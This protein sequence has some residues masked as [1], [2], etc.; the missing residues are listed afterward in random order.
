MY[1]NNLNNTLHEDA[2]VLI[3]EFLADVNNSS[4]RDEV[5]TLTCLFPSCGICFSLLQ[6][7]LAHQNFSCVRN[8]HCGR[9]CI[10]AAARLY[11]CRRSEQGRMRL[12]TF[13]LSLL[14][15]R[16]RLQETRNSPFSQSLTHDSHSQN[17]LS[18]TT[19]VSSSCSSATPSTPVPTSQ[20]GK[21]PVPTDSH[22]GNNTKTQNPLPPSPPV[23]ALQGLTLH[24]RGMTPAKWFCIQGLSIFSSLEYIILTEHQ[25]STEFQPDE[26]VKKDATSMS[27][28][29]LS[30]PFPNEDRGQR[31][32]GGLALL[33]RNSM[34]FSI[35]MHSLSGAVKTILGDNCTSLNSRGNVHGRGTSSSLLQAVTWS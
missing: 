11:L 19:P 30:Q 29:V 2:N 1:N 32:R 13:S 25:Q 10:T 24:I 18:H 15:P 27:Y 20:L 21:R 3:K 5:D 28:P 23:R 33:T 34:R 26:I 35:T 8:P 9:R 31:Y 12:H 17:T 7:I 6:P 4:L 16:Q 22:L 14:R